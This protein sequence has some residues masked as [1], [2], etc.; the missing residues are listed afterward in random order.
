MHVQASG[1]EARPNLRAATVLA[2]LH[3]RGNA[4]AVSGACEDG[5]ERMKTT[6]FTIEEVSQ[7]LADAAR[8]RLGLVAG[9]TYDVNL[10]WQITSD[11]PATCTITR[12]GVSLEK[13]NG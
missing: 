8:K 3:H 4:R 13:R 10:D 6:I 7:L 2:L 1:Q 5:S 12:V 9:G 11:V